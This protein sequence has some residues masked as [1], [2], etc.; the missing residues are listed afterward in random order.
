MDRTVV[1]LD[2]LAD[3]DRSGTKHQHLAPV[4]SLNLVLLGI[5]GIVVWSNRFE[6]RGAGIDHL[7]AGQDVPALAPAADFR[8]RPQRQLGDGPVGQAAPFC[9]PHQLRRHRFADD[10][11]FHG[12]NPSDLID[13]EGIDRGDPGNLR[14]IH[15]AAQGLG[16]H[17][18]AL[19]VAH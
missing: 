7:V 10:P 18:Q 16:D 3:T 12:D 15:A 1:K 5:R 19:V 17:E 14:R 9:G 2:A 6:F 8:F 13:K 4:G 11:L